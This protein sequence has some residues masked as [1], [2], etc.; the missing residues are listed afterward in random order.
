MSTHVVPR[1][2]HPERAG[3]FPEGQ[4]LKGKSPHP[5]AFRTTACPS[6]PPPPAPPRRCRLGWEEAGKPH[7][8]RKI[9]PAGGGQKFPSALHSWAAKRAPAAGPASDA[10]GLLPV[11]VTAPGAEVPPPPPAMQAPLHTDSSH[12]NT[13]TVNGRARKQYAR[14]RPPPRP[15]LARSPGGGGRRDHQPRAGNGQG[16]GL[17][18]AP[19]RA[20]AVRRGGSKSAEQGAADAPTARPLRAPPSQHPR[21]A[22]RAGT[23]GYLAAAGGR[24]HLRAPRPERDSKDREPEPRARTH[25][26]AGRLAPR[27]DA[28]GTGREV[29]DELATPAPQSSSRPPPRWMTA[30]SIPGW[31]EVQSP[32]PPPPQPQVCPTPS[33]GAPG[34]GRAE[35][36][37]GGGEV[38]AATAERDPDPPSDRPP[39]TQEAG[40]AARPALGEG[41]RGGAQR[42][43]TFLTHF[44]I[45]SRP[46]LL[47]LLPAGREGTRARESHPRA[48]PRPPRAGC[49]GRRA[50]RGTEGEGEA[51]EEAGARP[52]PHPGF[53]CA[54]PPPSH[55]LAST[56]WRPQP[57]A[58]PLPPPGRKPQREGMGPPARVSLCTPRFARLG[59]G[60]GGRPLPSCSALQ[61]A[62]APRPRGDRAEG[63]LPPTNPAPPPPPGGT[64][65]WGAPAPCPT[66]LETWAPRGRREGL[67]PS[68]GRGG[69]GEGR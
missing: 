9:G 38:S 62:K 28:V 45:P 10:P 17:P 24:R 30:V 54:A 21:R 43:V 46:L 5:G 8:L 50:P 61:T 25:G 16:A 23:P 12:E 65:R 48:I 31:M 3:T 18:A 22:P 59:A 66:P 39:A 47:L 15:L 20:G 69:G 6:T 57:L 14:T 55:G 51:T 41:V 63:I 40:A 56:C 49:A 1:S 58:E 37:G 52:R 34:Q 33:A 53:P 13:Y 7:N 32:T 60:A 68:P 26:G 35:P 19:L 2:A 42:P 36:P 44:R 67:L 27:H 29:G 64:G 11:L 4:H